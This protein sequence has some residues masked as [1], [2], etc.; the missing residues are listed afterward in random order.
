MICV[1]ALVVFGILGIF[2]S[3][4]R[5]IAKEAFGC[6]T[7]RIILKPCTTGLDERLKSKIT[8]SLMKRSPKLASITYK[9][10]E[11]ISWFFV[12]LLI[13]S[14]IYSG[15]GIYNL[16]IHGT[17][18]PENPDSCILKDTFEKVECTAE[19]CIK[20]GCIQTEE[21]QGDCNCEECE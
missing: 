10:F 4:H 13:G 20:G 19:E 3:T 6:V 2:S 18:T 11:L 15:I 9:N 8:G 14:I 17:C 1:I 21:C 7:R 16:S 5:K 12:V